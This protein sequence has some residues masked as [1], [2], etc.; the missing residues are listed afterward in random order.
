MLHYKKTFGENVFDFLNIVFMLFMI[1]ITLYP[2]VFVLMASL[3]EPMRFLAHRGVLVLPIGF[4]L[5]SYAAV[6]RNPNIASGYMNTIFIVG[7][8][9]VCNVIF[10]ALG[11]YVL[12]RKNLFWRPALTLICVVTMYIS[13]G[14]IP[15]YLVVR[16][17]HL[18]NNR[19]AL[20][21]PGLVSTYN[22]IV[23]RTAFAGIPESLEESARID[24][25]GEFR[26]LFRVVVPLALPTMAVIA[27]FYGVS[28][29]NSWFSA[30]IYLTDKS[31][32][33][34]QLVLRNIL[35]EAQT[36]ELTMDDAYG[37]RYAVAQT[38]K[39]ATIMVATVPI[40]LFYPF[41]QKYFVK[42]VMVGAIK[43]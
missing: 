43:G 11:A 15:N 21:L 5:S 2:F 20:I 42:G 19:M 39:Y 17:L 3:S 22:M 9:T 16:G 27:L 4:S 12:S 14:L 10:T 36:S 1:L 18:I 29:W 32:Q 33:P 8:G 7:I 26:I 30:M 41:L 35:I 38:V 24:G 34:L 23:M 40:L 13:G 25:A 28:H 31:K 37:D 6:I